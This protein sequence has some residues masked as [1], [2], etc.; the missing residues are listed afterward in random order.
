MLH[1]RKV[2]HCLS[3]R[4]D[5]TCIIELNLPMLIVVLISNVWTVASIILVP[6]VVTSRPLVTLVILSRLFSTTKMFTLDRYVC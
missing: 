1:G 5:E 6:F 3:E 4:V 2:L